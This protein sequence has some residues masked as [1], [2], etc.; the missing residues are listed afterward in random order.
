MKAALRIGL[1]SVAV[2]AAVAL[3]LVAGALAYW[4]A[5]GTG[6]A[7]ARVGTIAAPTIS[8]A[9]PG[10][11]T[12]ELSWTAVTPPDPGT[13]TY[14]VSRDGGE[15]AGKCPSSS[16]PSQ[17]TSCTDS[18]VSVGTHEY[19]VT[20]KWHSLTATS[21]S[22]SARVSFGP[23]T[24]FLLNVSTTTPS[25]GAADNLTITAEDTYGNT[26]TTYA[27]SHSL[28]FGG[29]A[30]IGTNHPTVTNSSGTVTSFGTATAISFA[31]GIASV[32]GT[33]NGVMK[34]YKAEA[35]AIT[36]AEGSITN[37][38]G[39][40]VTVGPGSAA[41]LSLAAATTTP[42]AGA[43]DNLTITAEDTYG[44]TVT[45]Y[46][47]SHSLTF[48][49]AATIGTN[50]P[51]VTNSSG[52]VTSFGTATAISF[53]SGIA[54]VSGTS[55][56]VMKLYKAEA[57]A[58]TVAEGSITNGSGL[59]VTVGPGSA[60]SLSLAAATTTPSA[61]AADNLTITAEDTYGNTVTTYAGSH[62][63]TFG[64]AA[65]IG[66]NH[67]TVTNSSGTVT[68]F[69]TAT[70]ISFASGIASVSG[71]SNGVMK[72]YKAEAAA[73]T[74]AEGSITNGSGLAVTVGPGSAAS[75]SLAAAT[76]TPSA[77]AA[78]NLTITA[79]DTYGNTVT[80]YA[81]SHSLTFG[82]AATIGTNHPTVTNS[83]GT[84]TSFGTATAISFA[85]GIASVSGTSNGVMKLYKA[86]AAAIT[87][88]EGSITNGSGLAV[89]VGPGSA[90]SLSLAAATTTPSA[91]AADNLTITAE[92]TYGNT[93]TTYA[94]SH[95]L[96]FGGAA[97]IG[98]NHPTVTNSSGTV[99]S[100]GTAT[101]ISFAS[102]IA[103]VSGTSN[104]V[105]KL[106]KAEAAAITVAEGS[107]T[108]GSGL[109][110]TVGPGSAASLSL[111]AATTTPSAGAADNLT[112]TAED[113]YGN[114]I[115]GSQNLTFE[116]AANSPNA[117]VPTVSNSSG[118]ATSFGTAT[119]ISFASGIASVSGADNGVMKLYSA[120]AA[121][122]IVSDGS[123][124]NGSGLA[125]TVS[126]GSASNLAWSHATSSGTL[127][128]PC[129]FTCTG[130]GLGS[131]GN[132]KA[133]VSVTDSSGNTVTGIGAGYTVSVTSTA[134]TITGG[135][136]TISAT[137]PAES[138]A[139]F[140]YTPSNG[141]TITLTA[142]TASGTTHTSAT[143]SMKK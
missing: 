90:A 88:A 142:A 102:G 123:I 15:P 16:S 23:A 29:A 11:G 56:G 129:L 125:V 87:V 60:A 27:G 92:D 22:E 74:V 101:A 143:A 47:G 80:T 51:T 93:V 91:G 97:T 76:T 113:T 135:T 55:N 18:G 95:S 61:G 127:S 109:A 54:S 40:A 7:S 130:T 30:T 32:S 65:T 85:S 134:G 3:C 10:A 139:Q 6:N 77:G 117:N 19:T 41:S 138:T 20:A 21:A 38:S 24:K 39:L 84:V 141:A 28:T 89:T 8:S 118:T 48:G 36:V 69:G 96:T 71:T 131:G 140:T 63:L 44:N 59:A 9:T 82:G 119:A 43:A 94:G 1:R 57:A 124:T 33:S 68:S 105:M 53:A 73:I 13:V 46:A 17:A 34:L 86:E 5:T 133:N 107:I 78:D 37:G 115:T 108:N 132:F 116:G 120:G 12:V 70:A 103:S 35:A 104:G 81:G 31:S 136:L 42:S 64:G 75:L 72:L 14:Y 126:P 50:H 137:G 121:S 2:A 111:A 49:G 4:T 26:V 62:S 112:I 58:I 25:A 106:Y 79:E 122:I 128:S 100:F 67:P 66:T 99:T 52:T 114:G 110:V 45:T 98:T 83:S